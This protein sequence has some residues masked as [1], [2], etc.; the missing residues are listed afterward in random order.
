MFLISF[1]VS[2][3]LS[4]TN[5]TGFWILILYP[6]TLLNSFISSSSFLVESSGFCMYSIISSA[7]KDGFTSS[8]P[9]WMPFISSSFLIA[10]ART[11]ST[12][13]TKRGESGHYCL[14]PDLK[15]N[16]CRFCPLSMMLAVGLSYIVFTMFRYVSSIPTL[17]RVFI[18][19]GCWTLS[20]AFYASIDMIMWF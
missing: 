15:G 13:L 11:P 19:N 7:N 6:A 9:I 18:I 5:A 4:Y 8:F 20:N 10:V 17:L 2:S 3:L 16:S 1:F 14:V 12:T